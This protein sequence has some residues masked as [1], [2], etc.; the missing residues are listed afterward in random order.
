LPQ[1]PIGSWSMLTAHSGWLRA[2]FPLVRIHGMR[3]LLCRESGSRPRNRIWGTCPRRRAF[4][5]SLAGTDQEL[6]FQAS[7]RRCPGFALSRLRRTAGQR[8]FFVKWRTTL[9]RYGS[10]RIR[11]AG[12]CP[13]TRRG[14]LRSGRRCLA[15]ER[16][17]GNGSVRSRFLHQE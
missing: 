6:H 7:A 16:A 10:Y 14:R 4:D 12:M 9:S 5:R 11:V 3:H 15:L 13:T 1:A 2:S 17:A 8:R